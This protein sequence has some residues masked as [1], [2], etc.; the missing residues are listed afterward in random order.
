MTGEQLKK[1]RESVSLSAAAASRQVEVNLRTWQRWESG[2]RRV[3]D[4]AVKL[5]KILNG[6]S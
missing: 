1:L 2:E 5:F 4:T 6:L 3:P